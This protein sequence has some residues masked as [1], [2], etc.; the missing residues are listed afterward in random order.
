MLH[1]II[2]KAQRCSEATVYKR[3]VWVLQYVDKGLDSGEACQCPIVVGYSPSRKT[4]PQRSPGWAQKLLVA[5]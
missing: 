4:L 2:G 5:V 1:K 3:C